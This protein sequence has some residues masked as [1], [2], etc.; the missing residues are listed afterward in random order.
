MSVPKRLGSK[1]AVA[2]RLRDLQVPKV[3]PAR[4]GRE[5]RGNWYVIVTRDDGSE[6]V[7]DEP[8]RR[9]EADK[10]AALYGEHLEGVRGVRVERAR[11]PS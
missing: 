8:Q 6:Y 9:D 5:K 4:G 2:W 10:L 11:G 7:I 1:P 3:P